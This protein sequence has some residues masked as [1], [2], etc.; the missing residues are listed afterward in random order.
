MSTWKS[1][2]WIPKGQFESRT[3]KA[4]HTERHT[5]LTGINVCEKKRRAAITVY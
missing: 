1:G 2:E 4:K 3:A 5:V